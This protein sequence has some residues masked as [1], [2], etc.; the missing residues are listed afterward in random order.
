LSRRAGRKG[1]AL[2]PGMIVEMGEALLEAREPLAR[3]L[4]TPQS[5]A[6]L[7]RRHG[8]HADPEDIDLLRMRPVFEALGQT[9]GV[10]RLVE[11]AR[12]ADEARRADQ[13]ASML[14]T[15]QGVA[16]AVVHMG[17]EIRRPVPFPFGHPAFWEE[18]PRELLDE[19]IVDHFALHRP[20][21]YAPL[22]LAGLFVEEIVD[23]RGAPGRDNY[24]R[25]KIRWDRLREELGSRA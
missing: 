15:L 23:V 5:F 18:F 21:D 6:V 2:P 20:L 7:L 4:A 13:A 17:R 25:R 3:H 11:S 12:A 19:L 10:R 14:D 1:A 24:S 8:W 9:A 22:V 16:T